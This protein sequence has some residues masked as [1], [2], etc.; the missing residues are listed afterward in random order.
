MISPDLSLIISCMNT[1]DLF[2]NN[3]NRYVSDGVNI[4]LKSF[5]NL[6]WKGDCYTSYVYEHIH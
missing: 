3:R 1:N 5:S 2:V 4:L 6:Y